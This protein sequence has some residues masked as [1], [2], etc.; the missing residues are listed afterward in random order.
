MTKWTIVYRDIALLLYKFWQKNKKAP[1]LSLYRLLASDADYRKTNS[2]L[3]KLSSKFA[4]EWLDPIQLFC[5]FSNSI[6]K[7]QAR[8]ANINHILRLLGSKRDYTEIDFAGCPAPFTIRMSS[9]RDQVVQKEI[10]VVFSAV[11]KDGRSGLSQKYFDQAR[12]W[13]GI[14]ISAFTIFLFWI[15]YNSFIPLDKHTV[16]YL[17][18]TK[19][20]TARPDTLYQ[21]VTLLESIPQSNIPNLVAIAYEQRSRKSEKTA[22]PA[23]DQRSQVPPTSNTHPAAHIASDF[24]VLGIQLLADTDIR[25][26]KVLLPGWY[27]CY[28]CYDFISTDMVNYRPHLDLD[29]YSNDK[30]KIQ[31]AA[32]VGP[33]GSGKSTFTELLYA[34]INNLAYAHGKFDEKLIPVTGLYLDLYFRTDFL[35]RLQFRGGEIRLFQYEFVENN[36]RYPQEIVSADFDFGQFFYSVAVNYAHYSLNSEHIGNWIHHLFHK[37]DGYQ[38]P[39]VINPY[40]KKGNIDVNREHDLLKNRLLANLLEP[41]REPEAGD[42]LKANMR[43]ITE[44]QGAEALTFGIKTSKFGRYYDYDK[45]LIN[46]YEKGK[47]WETVVPAI[48]E[49]FGLAEPSPI[50]IPGTNRDWLFWVHNYLLRKVVNIA[51]RYTPYKH[52]FDFENLKL[53]DI[54]GLVKLI[55]ADQSHITFKFKQAVNFLKFHQL[56]FPVVDFSGNKPAITLENLSISIERIKMAW[57]RESY[58]T[59]ELLPPSFID[60]DIV[61]NNGEMFHDL[62]SGEKQRI[63]TVSSVIYHLIN[64][65]SVSDIHQFTR[66]RYVNIIF[67]EVELYFHPEMQRAFIDYLLNYI[68]Y[69]DLNLSGL[70]FLFIT[71]S[72]FILSDIPRSNILFLNPKDTE[73]EFSNTLGANI[74]DLL[75]HSFFLHRGFMGE[76]IKQQI[77]N[78]AEFLTKPDTHMDQWNE[79]KARDVIDAIGEPLIKDRLDFLFQQKYP[80][81]LDLQIEEMEIKLNQLRDAKNKR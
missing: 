21:Y 51:S 71:H 43:Q 47:D 16:D 54:P 57:Q 17:Y 64:I 5:S 14:E 3:D 23:S 2:W 58:K 28:D 29:L 7:N 32:V 15:D 8:T 55:R 63:Y 56:I 50:V 80:G 72:P 11:I 12:N 52:H 9:A 49:E 24:R 38:V 25:L 81:D 73:L 27:L 60:T 70:N 42:E 20:I 37:N 1:E 78:L 67:D 77:N 53:K 18:A 22:V 44:K 31:I 26:R 4:S 33:N 48:Y 45:R 68:S 35:Y 66:Y 40:R 59:L 76:F 34:A 61:L 36:Y 62:S 10:W 6:Q 19:I 30:L 65:S 75:A 39:L 46:L 74:H 41:V 13:Y 79:G 69:I